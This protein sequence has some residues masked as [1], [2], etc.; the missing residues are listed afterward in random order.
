VN[1]W[2]F[3]AAA[4]LTTAVVLVALIVWVVMDRR[5]VTRRLAQLEAQGVR[6]RSAAGPR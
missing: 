6:R 1:P 2:G 5:V 3:I 4:Y